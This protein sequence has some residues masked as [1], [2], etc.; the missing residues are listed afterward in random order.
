MPAQYERK[1]FIL[2]ALIDS[3]PARLCCLGVGHLFG[4]AIRFSP[5]DS[6]VPLMHIYLSGKSQDFRL[7]FFSKLSRA[8]VYLP[9]R[10]FVPHKMAHYFSFGL[11]SP[12]KRTVFNT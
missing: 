12:L 4:K 7:R 11:T 1:V 10:R 9:I 5:A 8:R 6:T 3:V 2:L